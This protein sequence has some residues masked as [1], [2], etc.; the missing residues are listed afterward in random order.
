MR[1]DG[2]MDGTTEE[3]VALYDD[4][5]RPC[6]SAPRSRMRAENLRHAATSVVVRNSDGLFYVHRRTDTKD[7]YPG[8]HDFACG[9]VLGA[10]EEPREAAIRELGEELGITGVTLTELGAVDY[11]DD[12]T[13]YRAF[14][15]ATSWDGPISWQP[16]EVASGE[17]M[18]REEVL[19]ALADPG[20]CVPDTAAV[21]ADWL[22]EADPTARLLR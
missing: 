15:Y 5:G 17:W 18:T 6:G 22:A 1:E 12:F 13:R 7:V 4:R 16:E 21:F 8:L 10:G 19:A 14:R 9:G 2:V 11:A 3:I 20:W